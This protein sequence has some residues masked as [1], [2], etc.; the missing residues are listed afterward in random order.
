MIGSNRGNRGDTFSDTSL[1][2]LKFSNYPDYKRVLELYDMWDEAARDKDFYQ[3][4]HYDWEI[5]K[6]HQKNGIKET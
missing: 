3:A 4:E 2:K 1:R 6:I 5:A